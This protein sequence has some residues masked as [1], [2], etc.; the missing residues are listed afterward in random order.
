MF[1][2]YVY[3]LRLHN[4][5]S[6]HIYH[7]LYS[8][9]LDVSSRRFIQLR[10]NSTPEAFQLEYLQAKHFPPPQTLRCFGEVFWKDLTLDIVKSMLFVS[11]ENNTA[12]RVGVCQSILIGILTLIFLVTQTVFSASSFTW[13]YSFENL[14]GWS[15]WFCNLISSENHK[16]LPIVS[17]LLMVE[18]WHIQCVH[19]LSSM[20]PRNSRNVTL[21][22]KY[23]AVV[24]FW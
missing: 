6:H 14:I 20:S 12:W 11:F 13:N 24:F 4:I 8:I 2:C 17:N 7:I 18:E 21:R 3:C 10:A 22:L 5:F 15:C 19:D 16:P 23:P 9:S 1:C